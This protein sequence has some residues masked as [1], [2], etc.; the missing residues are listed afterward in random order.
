MRE[1]AVMVDPHDAYECEADEEGEIRR[2]LAQ[3]LAGEIGYVVAR[4][5]DFEDEQRDGD[6]EYAVRKS[7]K[8]CG[9]S[10]QRRVP[11]SAQS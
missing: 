6:G 11:E 10:G 8:A 5:F 4:D 3:E 7:L 9:F 2:P 1:H